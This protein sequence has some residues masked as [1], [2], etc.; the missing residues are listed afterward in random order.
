MKL[1]NFSVTE[2]GDDIQA[3][4]RVEFED[5]DQPGRDIYIRTSK[6]YKDDVSAD[7]QAFLVGCLLPAMHFGEQR[8][9]VDHELCPFL[10]EGLT[11]VMH[12]IKTWTDGAYQPLEIEARNQA[13][14]RL[15]STPRAGM[16][17]SGGMDSLAALYLNRKRYP[18]SHPAF[19]KDGLFLHGFD[20]GGVVKRGM[21]YH[22]FERAI[23]SIS[24]I[25]RDA[26]CEL[27]PVYTNIRHLCDERVLWLNYF[28]G[29]VLAA[30]SHTFSNRLN[31]MFIGS[32]YDIPNLHPCGSHPLL[33]PEYSSYNMRIRHR[34]H[35]LSRLEKIDLISHWDIAFQNFRVCLANVPDRLNCGNCEK[36]VRTMTE[37]TALGLLEKTNAFVEDEITPDHISQFDITIRERPPFYRPLVPQLIQ[38]GRQD[39]ANAI[40]AQVGD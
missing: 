14:P 31:L 19:V 25:T 10:K 27:I 28:F 32:S 29:S 11:V 1:F 17:M 34:D 36:C 8:I 16:F 37:L 7:P 33:D 4:A 2:H 15:L 12:I 6:Q 39:L 5:C 3:N 9:K 24:K 26:G 21:K 18:E 20:I 23:S 30:I 13:A 35:E 38:K 22:V 40:K